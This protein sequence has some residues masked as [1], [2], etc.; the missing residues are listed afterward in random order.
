MAPNDD[1]TVKKPIHY[2]EGIK[3]ELNRIKSKSMWEHSSEKGE[4]DEKNL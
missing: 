3:N 4:S 2:L 1:L